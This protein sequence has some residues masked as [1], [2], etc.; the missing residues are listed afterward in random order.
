MDAMVEWMDCAYMAQKYKGF[1]ESTVS[2][3]AWVGRPD[4]GLCAIL[5]R[6][7]AGLF[8]HGFPDNFATCI[9]MWHRFSCKFTGHFRCDSSYWRY[10]SHCF[11]QEN[12]PLSICKNLDASMLLISNMLIIG[13]CNIG[14]FFAWMNLLCTLSKHACSISVLVV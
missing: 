4:L 10:L 5:Q 3:R 13:D 14:V 12:V 8:C 1:V 7:C 11:G 6:G 9:C 2:G